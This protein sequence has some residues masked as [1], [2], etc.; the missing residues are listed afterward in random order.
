VIRL[1]TWFEPSESLPQAERH[2][3]AFLNRQLGDAIPFQFL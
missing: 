1:G 2:E 3:D